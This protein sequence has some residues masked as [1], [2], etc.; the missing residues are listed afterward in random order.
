MPLRF[1]DTPARQAMARLA[2][3]HLG[4]FLKRSTSFSQAR[5]HVGH[6]A[7]GS[8]DGTPQGGS[9]TAAANIYLQ[10]LAAS[11]EHNGAEW[12]LKSDDFVT[13]AGRKRGR[14]CA[15]RNRRVTRPTPG[16][17]HPDKTRVA[18]ETNGQASSSLLPV[19]AGHRFVRKKPESVQGQGEGQNK[20]SR[21]TCLA[22]IIADLNPAL[23]GCFGYFKHATPTLF[24]ET[25]IVSFG[26]GAPFF[27]ATDNGPSRTD[28]SRSP[29]MAQRLPS[30]HRTVSLLPALAQLRHHPDGK[31]QQAR[32]AVCGR[33]PFGSEGGEA[34]WTAGRSRNACSH[35]HPAFPRPRERFVSCRRN[36]SSDET[37]RE[38]PSSL[39]ARSPP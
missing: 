1:F 18:T 3:R 34:G 36:G 39:A 6:G 24:F 19:R 32:R 27:C 25:S 9:L 12:S 15:A 10:P 2:R 22:R 11:E 29:T 26:D 4:R 5:D 14:G 35:K 21:V 23:R 37:A 7:L 20:R 16:T 30:K 31:L 13:S 8:R 33:P 28:A 17:L 38:R